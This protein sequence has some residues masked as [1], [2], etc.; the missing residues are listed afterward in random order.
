MHGRMGIEF[1][2]ADKISNDCLE[3]CRYPATGNLI[4][5]DIINSLRLEGT[6]VKLVEH[7]VK[8][9][10]I[11][12]IDETVWMTWSEHRKLHNRL[13]KEGKCRIPVKELTTISNKANRRTLKYKSLQ[14]RLHRTRINETKLRFVELIAPN[15]S[16]IEV[17]YYYPNTGNVAITSCF[18]GTHG[19]KLKRINEQSQIIGQTL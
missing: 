9:K 5:F 15:V 13:R 7:H 1:M 11:H 12:G 6:E 2:V 8:Y 4:A 17:Y 10:E 16:L 19:K 18:Y 3:G 14:C